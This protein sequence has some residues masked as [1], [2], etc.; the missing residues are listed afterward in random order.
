[1][2]V[3]RG[4]HDRRYARELQIGTEPL[5]KSVREDEDDR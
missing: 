1:M 5:R 2:S 3:P 4:P